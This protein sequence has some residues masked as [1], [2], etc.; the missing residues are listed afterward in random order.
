MMFAEVE[1]ACLP[2][3][4]MG[5]LA[6]L[7]CAAGVEIA[8][9]DRHLWLRWNAGDD[10]VAQLLFAIVGC[11]LLA[12]RD[13]RWYD[14]GRSVPAFDIPEGLRY[15]P[16]AQVIFPAS[17]Q[18]VA[19]DSFLPEPM[20]LTLV[21]DSAYRPTLALLTSMSALMAWAE[22]TP[23]CALIHYRAAVDGELLF[24]LGKKLPWIDGADRFW[25]RTVL[26]PL[27]YRPEPQLSEAALRNLAGVADSDLL[28]LRPGGCDIIAQDHFAP[29]THAALRL[30]QLEAAK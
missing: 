13:G 5:R 20:P 16:L 25:G 18:P 4:A 17:I 23:P 28:V 30:A 24:V 19:A 26:V 10:Q 29:L 11:R 2:T 9:H 15:R 12:E 27:G 22:A 8:L 14:W 21:P 7:R 1:R 6:A 3:S